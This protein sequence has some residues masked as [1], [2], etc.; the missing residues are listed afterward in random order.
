[1]NYIGELAAL[2]TALAFAIN[3]G[4]FAAAGRR[5]GAGV[6][7]RVRLIFAALFVTLS[8]W[9]FLGKPFPWDAEPERWLWLGLSGLVGFVLGDAFL[10]QAFVWVGARVSML[11]MSL[12]PVIAALTA[13]IFLGESLT[14]W[15]MMGIVLTTSG[16]AWV[17]WEGNDS[18]VAQGKNYVKGILFGLGGAIGQALGVVLAKNGMQPINDM[19]ESF[20]PLSGNFIRLITAVTIMWAY[21]IFKGE[22]KNTFQQ[23]VGEGRALGSIAGGAFVGPFLGVSLS[24]FALQ[25]T[26]VGIASTF[27]ALSPVFLLPIGY[28]WF[29]ERFGWG[30]VAGTLLAVAG[31]ALLILA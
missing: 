21:T 26:S 30:A 31:V 9:I 5:V 25:Y 28:F 20:S 18:Q 14:F 22:G 10:F 11:M 8:H 12:A 19:G 13:W 16:V 24:L 2:A 3:S 17:L 1:M 23:L 29:K 27:M 6:V 7:N 4:L 15:Q